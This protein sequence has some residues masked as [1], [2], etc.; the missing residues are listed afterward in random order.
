MNTSKKTIIISGPCSVESDTQVIETAKK[1]AATGKVDYLRGGIWKPRTR[2]GSFEGMGAQALP[3]LLAAKQESGLPTAVEVATAKQVE[4]ALKHEV[5]LLWIGARTTV[6]P[7]SVQEVADALQGVEKTILIKNPVNPDLELWIGALER[8]Q[9]A[10]NGEIGLIHRGFSS[11]G[12]TQYRNAPM[13]HI[14]IE[15]RRRFPDLIMIC[16]PSHIGGNRELIQSIA[17][18]AVDLN[19]DGLMIESHLTPDLALSDAKQQVTPEEFEQIINKIIWRSEKVDS[20]EFSN[21]LDK[22]R[23]QINQIDDELYQLLAQRMRV[24]DQIGL[25]KKQNGVTIL[26]A[27]RWNEIFDKAML[28]CHD[29]NLSDTFIQKY[30]EAIH[31]E[32][33]R[34]QNEVMNK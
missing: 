6:N 23:E 11:F 16:D 10:V 30:L 32:S 26:Q 5:D 20:S 21:A 22:L 1:L 9:K 14:A 8:I 19:Y 28:K 27:S 3:W 24:A 31:I 2:P 7:F 12:N 33:I 17:Q 15:M 25:Y 29:L 13:W 18:R 34:H 4:D